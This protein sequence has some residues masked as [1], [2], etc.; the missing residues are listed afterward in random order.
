MEEGKEGSD[1]GVC[2]DGED[3]PPDD[4]RYNGEGKKNCCFNQEH[5]ED[6]FEAINRNTSKVRSESRNTIAHSTTQAKPVDLSWTVH[7]QF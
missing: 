4:L 5:A 6:K 7:P 1:E 3:Q 2:M